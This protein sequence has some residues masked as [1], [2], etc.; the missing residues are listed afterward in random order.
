MK[1]TNLYAIT[2]LTFDFK[3]FRATCTGECVWIL[4]HCTL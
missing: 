4:L 1:L 3:S 2:Q